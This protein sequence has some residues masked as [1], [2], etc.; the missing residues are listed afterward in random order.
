MKKNAV[1][2]IVVIIVLAFG[3]FFALQKTLKGSKQEI[4]ISNKEEDAVG[5][6]LEIAKI[7]DKTE[8]GGE[9]KD[10]G[11]VKE[12]KTEEKNIE[13]K[14][15]NTPGIS[16]K[17]VSWGHQESSGR[18]INTIIIHSSYNALGG[19]EYD[20]GKLIGEYKSYGVSPHYLIDREGKIYCLVEE[21]NIAYHAGESKTPDGRSGVNNFSVGIEL[22]NTK[23]DKNTS[24]QYN[25]LRVLLAYLKEKYTIKY[26]LGHNQ[27]ASGR[28][29]DPW[30]FDWGKIK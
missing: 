6:A 17:L 7:D 22:M 23:E 30:N 4:K 25:S 26:I 19:D 13:K 24:K 11:D 18:V 20:L 1:I 28:K 14:A 9:Q 16:N 2:A 8:I 5:D 12:E 3:L 15:I 10:L 21:R 27:I 29:D